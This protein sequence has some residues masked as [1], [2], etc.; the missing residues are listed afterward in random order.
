MAMNYFVKDMFLFNASEFDIKI[1]T[2]G[3]EPSTSSYAYS[4]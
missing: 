3:L 2:I 4:F 1:D